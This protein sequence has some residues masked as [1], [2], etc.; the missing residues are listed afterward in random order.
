[1]IVYS[2]GTVST[3]NLQSNATSGVMQVVGPAALSTRIKT[4]RDANDTI[5]ELGGSYTPTGI[6]TSMSLTTPTVT[7]S[8]T[9][10][11]NA[12]LTMTS[13]TGIFTQTYTSTTA[14]TSVSLTHA[15][16][17][18][19]TFIAHQINGT[20]TS[21]ANTINKTTLDVESTGTWNGTTANNYAIYSNA[22]GG[23]TN[24][25][26]YGNS[27]TLYNAGA[28]SFGS[29]VNTTGL[30][31]IAAT[32]TSAGGL[33]LPAVQGLGNIWIVA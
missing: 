30:V 7:T 12:N 19:A 9:L 31:T 32:G 22:T 1:M 5:L 20:A 16:A 15:G 26:F 6:W 10:N 27:G 4:I 17:K 29:T 24:Y 13:G 18:S 21:S 28:A 25:S 2:T 8:L 14:T 3:L 33:L 11:A 23:T